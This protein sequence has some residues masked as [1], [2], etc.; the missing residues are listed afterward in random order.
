[1]SRLLGG[2]EPICVLAVFQCLC[3]NLHLLKHFCE[4][5]KISEHV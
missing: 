4:L 2:Y 5:L 1:M 3:V